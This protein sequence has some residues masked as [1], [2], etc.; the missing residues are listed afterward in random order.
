MERSQGGELYDIVQDPREEKNRVD[1]AGLQGERERLLRLL[2]AFKSANRRLAEQIGDATK[3]V[4]STDVWEQ[5][6]SLG[7]VK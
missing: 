2:R 6:K 5:L 7:Y 1:E 3:P 4:V